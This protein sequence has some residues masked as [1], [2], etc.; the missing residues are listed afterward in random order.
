MDIH[1]RKITV[2]ELRRY[3]WSLYTQYYM[4]TMSKETL[5]HLWAYHKTMGLPYRKHDMVQA[6]TEIQ[7][8][9]SQLTREGGIL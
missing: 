3:L 2:G 7:R 1:N 4:R 5:A 8:E 9:L 6:I